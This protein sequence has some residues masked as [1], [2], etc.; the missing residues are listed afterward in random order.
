ME[1]QEFQ[2]YTR[3]FFP[4]QNE[5]TNRK[6]YAEY[7]VFFLY[8]LPLTP[9]DR[10]NLNDLFD[11]FRG[12]LFRDFLNCRF[13]QIKFPVM[14]SGWKFIVNFIAEFLIKMSFYAE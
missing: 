11:R 2:Q 12:K 8:L 5:I 6:F 14:E 3:G 10:R 9:F 7:L 13:F 1:I 4:N